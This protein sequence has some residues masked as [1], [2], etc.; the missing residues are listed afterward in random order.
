MFPFVPNK[1]MLYAI[2]AIGILAVFTMAYIK[3]R[4][5]GAA[6]ANAQVY[7]EKI[8]WESK[9]ATIQTDYDN[10]VA[11]L[12][13][14]YTARDKLF[15]AEIDK[16]KAKDSQIVRVYIPTTVDSFVPKGFVNLHNTTAS[17]LSLSDADQVSAVD[18]SDK[19]LSDVANIIAINYNMCN[20]IALQLQT[21]QDIVIEFQDKQRRLIK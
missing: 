7:E 6:I 20:G 5:D 18:I 17:G 16:L 12:V 13:V 19:K 8:K 15:R 10:K 11:E 14:N 9:V 1:L 2:L 3:G 21:L 4:Y